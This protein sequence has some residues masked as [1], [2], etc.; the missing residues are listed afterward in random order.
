MGSNGI[1]KRSVN[2]SGD[3]HLCISLLYSVSQRVSVRTDEK[4]KKKMELSQAGMSHETY[5]AKRNQRSGYLPSCKYDVL[6]Q[7]FMEI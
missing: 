2:N 7:M 6:Y 1:R 4:G 3:L 5:S